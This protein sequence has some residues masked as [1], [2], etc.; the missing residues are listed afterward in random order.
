M[1]IYHMCNL[2][3]RARR[4]WLVDM[5][6]GPKPTPDRTAQW[7]KYA[8]VYAAN[9]GCSYMAIIGPSR[10][11]LF[12]RARWTIWYHMHFTGASLMDI[13]RASGFDHATVLNGIRRIKGGKPKEHKKYDRT[14]I[15]ML[16]EIL[17][18]HNH[19]DQKV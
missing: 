19:R 6:P 14:R 16:A 15:E 8:K 3:L 10:N 4:F 11:P 5:K 1:G 13:E 12:V 18:T 17:P 9:L 2:G 7:L